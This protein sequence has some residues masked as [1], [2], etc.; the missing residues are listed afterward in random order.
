MTLITFI[1][2]LVLAYL[3]LSVSYYFLFAVA[4]IF[5]LRAKKK[6]KS[7]LRKFAVLI[8]GYKEDSVI[9]DV[10]WQALTQTYNNEQFDVI[11]IADSF[12]DTTLRALRNLPIKVVE[13]SFDISTK[14]KALNAAMDQIGNAYDVAL[15]LDADNI[16]EPDFLKKVN[17]AF[18]HGFLA[19]QGRRVA[20]NLNTN[21]AILDAIS[22]EIGNN[23]FRKGHRV[24]GFSSCLAGSGMAFDYIYFKTIMKDVNA[25]GGFDKELEVRILKD[26]NKIEYL[27]NALVYDEK[28]QKADTFYKQR[29]RWLSTQSTYLVKALKTAITELFKKGNFDLFDKVI[30]WIYPPKLLLLAMVL[31]FSGVTLLFAD[32]ILL[33]QLTILLAIGTVL[34]FVLSIPRKFYSLNTLKAVVSL[35]YALLLMTLALFRLK[36]ANKKFIHTQHGTHN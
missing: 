25:V 33:K 22:E 15:V 31:I 7:Q 14:S 8:P 10:A 35:P 36:G 20:K 26:Q 5:P 1:V 2:F 17:D 3:L 34:F 29:R 9:V 11:V 21:F 30:Q 19:V 23:V 13:V 27:P 12:K 24:L 18:D 32:N 28:V 4:S 16:M 6:N